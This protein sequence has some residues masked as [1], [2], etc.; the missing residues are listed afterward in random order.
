MHE[1]RIAGC[2]NAR[3][4]AAR[5]ALTHLAWGRSVRGTYA[6]PDRGPA[7]TFEEEPGHFAHTKHR[8]KIMRKMFVL[9][10][11][12]ALG[13]AGNA[14]AAEMFKDYVPSK[15]V[16]NVTMVKVNPNHIDDY[17]GGLK[18]S[19]MNGCAAGKK[20]GTLEDC[21][22][23]VSETAAGGPFNV[24]LVQKFTSSA[25]MEPNEES[26]NKVMAEVRKNLAEAKEKELV[27]GYEEYRTFF[28]EMNFR[29]I[30]WK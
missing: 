12:A 29:R 4:D 14:N 27:K 2:C 1:S 5:I 26:Y 16:W 3:A 18:Q 8:K 7:G 15:A 23:F 11:V 28:G 22:I 30:E 21:S 9:A 24:M 20:A 6:P 10:A 19:W 13:L 25:M 17:L